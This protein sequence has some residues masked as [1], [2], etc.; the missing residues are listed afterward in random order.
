MRK[1]TTLLLGAAALTLAACGTQG[2]DE[3]AQN[4]EQS[5]ENKADQLEAAADNASGDMAEN[6]QGTADVLEDT[7]DAAADSIDDN[8]VTN[9]QSNTGGAQSNVT[10]M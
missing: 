4:V 9:L 10:G 2:D 1:V 8:D 6:M 7:G 3:L 5:F